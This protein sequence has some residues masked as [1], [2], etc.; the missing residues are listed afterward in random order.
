MSGGSLR[1]DKALW[2]LRLARTRTLAQDWVAE[3]RVRIDGAR[4]LKPSAPV[5]VGMEIV[6][7]LPG[8]LR[9]IRLLALPLRRGPASE[10]RA[11]YVDLRAAATGETLPDAA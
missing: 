4:A 11:C 8:G 5:A 10:A 1:V 7:N 9:A 3:G 2:F 6:L